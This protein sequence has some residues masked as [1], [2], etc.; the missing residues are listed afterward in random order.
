[1]YGHVC[2]CGW[3]CQVSGFFVRDNYLLIGSF[4]LNRMDFLALSHLL[5]VW[6][7]PLYSSV[8]QLSSHLF[9]NFLSRPFWAWLSLH[10]YT[11]MLSYGDEHNFKIMAVTLWHLVLVSTQYVVC[12]QQTV[13]VIVFYLKWNTLFLGNSSRWLSD[14]PINRFPLCK[15]WGYCMQSAY[16]FLPCMCVCVATLQGRKKSSHAHINHDAF[17]SPASKV[18]NKMAVPTVQF[19]FSLLFL[20]PICV[21]EWL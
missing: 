20:M 6:F 17:S 18:R 21:D 10:T 19:S 14:I 4:G 8:L 1:M 11:S 12:S 16:S 5:R 15:K 9:F 7:D 2:V 3:K 13:L